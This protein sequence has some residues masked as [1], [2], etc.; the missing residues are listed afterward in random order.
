MGLLLN[1]ELMR[2]MNSFAVPA[3]VRE[4]LPP[5]VEFIEKYSRGASL[6]PRQKTLLKIIFLEEENFDDYDRLVIEQWMESTR[7]GGEVVIP[8]DLYDRIRWCKEHGYRHFKE[9][10]YC[11]GRRGGKGFIGGKIGEYKTAQMIALGNPQRFYE[12]DESKDIY[13]DILATQ[14][15]QAQGMLYNDIKDAILNNDWLAPY[16]YSTSNDMQKLQTPNDRAREERLLSQQTRKNSMRA[17]IASIIIKPS[18]ASS[19]AIRGRASFMQ[20]FDEFAHGLDTGSVVSSEAIY[21]AATPSLYQFDKDGLI[22]IPSSPW[23]ETGKFYELYQAAFAMENGKSA[24]PYMFAIKI[25]SW[26]PYEDWQYDHRKSRAMI[27]PPSKSQEMRQKELR[28]PETFNVEFRANFAKT[29]NAYMQPKIVDELFLPYPSEEENKNYPKTSGVITMQYRAHADAGR[30]QDNFCF[31]MGHK[32]LG[33][34]GYWHVFIDVM[35]VWQ[36]SD[37]PIDDE[38]VRRIDYTVP[39]QWFKETFKRFYVSRFT[40]D[41]W[42]SGMFLDELRADTIRGNF[43]NKSM[44]VACDTHTSASNFVRWERFK[45]ACYQNWVHIPY[46]EQEITGMGNVSLIDTELKFLVVKNG[47]KVDHPDVGPWQH[48]DMAD[49]VSTVVSDLLADQLNA[50]EAGSLTKVVGAAQGGYNIGGDGFTYGTNVDIEAQL[51]AQSQSYYEQ[52]GYG[53]YY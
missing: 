39:M 31:A 35:K 42:N 49:C 11:G 43:V 27:L 29:E 7:N 32:E 21:E 36:P 38:G 2:T 5:V 19:S 51:R 45:T 22:Y 15:S 33:E 9:I 53:S 14:F 37:F 40:M 52:A 41:Q 10:I 23:S 34:D 17:S 4:E 47:N 6:Y 50:L 8:L 18:A 24:N 12:I 13:L 46:I 16:I 25:P 3:E 44:S 20:C 28:N 48:N 1:H 30:S 26:G